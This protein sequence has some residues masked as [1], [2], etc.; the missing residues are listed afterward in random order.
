[1]NMRERIKTDLIKYAKSTNKT[2]VEAI[3]YLISLSSPSV[4][5]RC[6]DYPKLT[7]DWNSL[8][9]LEDTH[10]EY[11]KSEALGE[12]IYNRQTDYICEDLNEGGLNL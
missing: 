10:L 8:Q 4:L 9:M 7:I 6:V 1:M 2:I 5:E 12:V 3:D 11:I